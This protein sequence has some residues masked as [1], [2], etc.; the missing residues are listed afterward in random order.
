[1]KIISGEFKTI[2]TCVG[3]RTIPV[4]N[5]WWEGMGRGV[6][7]EFITPDTTMTCRVCKD[8]LAE[9]AFPTFTIP[10]KD[11]RKRSDECRDCRDARK[12]AEAKRA[13]RRAAAQKGA[14]TRAAKKEA[15]KVAA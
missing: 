14:A 1:M 3:I 11:G 8:E 6:T 9:T 4:E 15:A 12:A 13:A 7:R 5:R 2:D 10:R